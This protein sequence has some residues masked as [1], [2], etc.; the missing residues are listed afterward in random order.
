MRK[1]MMLCAWLCAMAFVVATNPAQAAGNNNRFSYVS[2]TGSD[3]NNCSNPTTQA[4]ASFQAALDQTA[5][6]GEIDCVNAGSYGLP[7]FGVTI[8]QSVTID[9]AGGVGSLFNGQISVNGAGIVVRFRNLTINAEG[10]GAITIDA[11]KMA[12]LYVENCVMTNNNSTNGNGSDFFGIKFEPSANAQLFVSNSVITNNGSSTYSSGGGIDIA[13]ASGVTAT[14]SIDRSQINGN[15]FGII[16]DGTKGGVIKGTV[17][18]SVV[19][20]NSQNGIT[21]S[22]TGSSVVL[23]VDQT[24]VAS[25]GNHGLVAGGSGAGML[26]RNTNVFNN[27]CGLYTV[28]DG[29]LYSYGN[30]GVNGNN[31][32]D[33]TFTGTSAFAGELP[34]KGDL[35]DCCRKAWRGCSRR[36]TP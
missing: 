24:T 23:Q 35:A 21:V 11:Q 26:V 18:D 5:N 36:R 33:G 6:L 27:G 2:N 30:N 17:T 7:G 14:V 4:C 9:C 34:R 20:G 31:G 8:T 12:S 16:A 28:N 22:S 10:N 13:P 19:S 3:M 32:Q 15:L 29:A 25:N 1:L